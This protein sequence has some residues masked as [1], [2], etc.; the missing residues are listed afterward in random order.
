M[1][2]AVLSA[3]L[4][5]LLV[6]ACT[7]PPPGE[8]P[9]P[10]LRGPVPVRG[11]TPLDPALACLRTRMPEGADLRFAVWRIPDRTG[12]TDYDGPGRYVPQAAELM[13]TTALARTGVRL[14]NR[15]GVAV[16]EWE[17]KQALE[18]R[19]GEGE[20][21]TVGERR[22]PFRPVRMGQLLG[23]THTVFGAVTELDFDILSGG[24]EASVGGLG[25]RARSYY[26]ALGIDI[27]VAD[28]RTTEIVWAR[29]YRKQIWGREVEAGLFRFF[30]VNPGGNGGGV[31]GIGAELFDIRLG[32]RENEP[33]HAGLR[34][35]LAQ[36]AYDIVRDFTGAGTACDAHVP[37]PSLSPPLRVV[38]TGT[39]ED[40]LDEGTKAPAADEA[41]AP[42][43]AEPPGPPVRRLP[44]GRIVP[45]DGN[46]AGNGGS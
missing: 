44:G 43:A 3:P 45:A 42:G 12:V 28:T 2:R 1:R 29:S 32:R 21:V 9:R 41:F 5:V 37:A 14:V 30:D 15:T 13:L 19:L 36:A 10:P 31:G 20:P 24:V 4:F 39:V 23:S 38:A 27:V 35:L 33:V 18:K 7:G 34:W 46:G 25:A 17:L 11:T 40:V 8:A 22:Y 6:A 26:V 16:S